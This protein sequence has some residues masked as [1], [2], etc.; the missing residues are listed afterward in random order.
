[1]D[2]TLILASQSPQRLR[3]LQDYGFTIEVRIPQIDETPKS[4][5]FPSAL[6]ERL[7]LEKLRDVV[8][9]EETGLAADT[10][11]VIDNEI[12]GKP[13]TQKRA[14]AMLES[15]SGRT[16]QIVGGI[17][18]RHDCQDISGVV[19]SEVTFRDLTDEE[20]EDYVKTGEP[21]DKAGGYAIQGR[22]ADLI[23][24]V[25]GCQE[26]VIGLSMNAV[27][28]LMRLLKTHK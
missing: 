15:L 22:G 26:N 5:E 19:S 8:E 20:I 17:A 14:T 9:V 18:F 24:R 4:G 2:K 23:S 11:A 16:H 7:A 10:V 13:G 1:M 3:L 12:L 25:H 6:V 27:F 28:E 21:L